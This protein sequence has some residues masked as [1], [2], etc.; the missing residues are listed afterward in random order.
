MLKIT[1]ALALA[2][3]AVFVW[4]AQ[5]QERTEASAHS[6]LVDAFS[7][8]V[9]VDHSY[10]GASY[11]GSGCRGSV[12]YASP[13][14]IHFLS[15]DYSKLSSVA[16]NYI[17]GGMVINVPVTDHTGYS[18]NRFYVS[19]G[20][21]ELRDRASAALIFLRDKCDASRSTGF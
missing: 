9:T 16:T 20:S 3:V 7:R 5:A 17:S 15:I 1:P 19:F 13:N 6:F 8:N 21:D 18:S 2:L 10:K 14:G 11:S 4:G 12:G